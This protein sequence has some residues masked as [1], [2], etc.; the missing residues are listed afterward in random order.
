MSFSYKV[1]TL[2]SGKSY[3]SRTQSKLSTHGD[4][5]AEVIESGLT[6]GSEE[7]NI[8]F[9][10]EIIQERIKAN[11]TEMMDRLFHGNLITESTTASTRELRLQH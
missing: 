5:N 9:S 6:E 4:D 8:R 7:S 11:L 10:Q 3:D 2:R 1:K